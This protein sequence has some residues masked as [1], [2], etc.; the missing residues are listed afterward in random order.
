MSDKAALKL[1][2][3]TK[4]TCQNPDCGARFYDL[5]RDPVACPICNTVYAIALQSPPQ[6]PARPAPRP[7]KRPA[8]VPHALKEEVPAEQGVELGSLEGEDEPVPVAED[9]DTFIEEVDE[10][11]TDVS[12]ILDAPAAGEEDKE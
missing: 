3:G 7:V 10:D 1:D 6:A 4:R 9:D 2:R 11:S 5:N 8:P 12:G